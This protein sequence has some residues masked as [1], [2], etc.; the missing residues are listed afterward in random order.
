MI[1]LMVVA[2]VT[3]HWKVGFFIFL[4]DGGW[5]Y[6]AS[7]LVTAWGV[8]AVGP[9]GASLDNAWSIDLGNNWAALTPIIGIGGAIVH[10]LAFYR[11]MKK[12]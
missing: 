7:I 5:E 10:L 11:P 6:C 3:V 2:I 12:S 8:A 9:G 1:G 4:P